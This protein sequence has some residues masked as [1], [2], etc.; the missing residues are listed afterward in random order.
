M[1]LIF[2]LCELLGVMDPDDFFELDEW[3]QDGWMEHRH[4]KMHGLY[5]TNAEKTQRRHKAAL[6]RHPATTRRR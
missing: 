4:N 1:G 6:A 5:E 3:K 2:E